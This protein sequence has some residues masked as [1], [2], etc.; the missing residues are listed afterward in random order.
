MKSLICSN[1]TI[2][3]SASAQELPPHAPQPQ[4][5]RRFRSD[6]HGTKREPHGL[7]PDSD[8]RTSVQFPRGAVPCCA[9]PLFAGPRQPCLLCMDA[10]R[11]SPGA[12]K[13]SRL[14]RLRC[15]RLKYSRAPAPSCIRVRGFVE[16]HSSAT[17]ENAGECENR[18]RQAG[19]TPDR[20]RSPIKSAKVQVGQPKQAN[21]V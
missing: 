13:S 20:F 2:N 18:W 8:G 5:R 12:L 4:D 11:G 17:D 7:G 6:L 15:H 19:N 21:R 10:L 14:F 3:P 1:V 16:D 9:T